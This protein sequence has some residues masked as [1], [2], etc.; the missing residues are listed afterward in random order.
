MKQSGTL[1]SVLPQ[2]KASM[3]MTLHVGEA[4]DTVYCEGM[5]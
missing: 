1:C 4:A 5:H 3:R 2:S